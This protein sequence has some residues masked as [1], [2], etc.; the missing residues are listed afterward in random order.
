VDPV[1]DPLLH[2]KSQHNRCRKFCA[3][4]DK[5]TIEGTGVDLTDWYIYISDALSF[6]T[7][8][9]MMETEKIFGT[10]VFISTLTRLIGR[11]NLSTFIRRER[12]MS[13]EIYMLTAER[14]TT[15]YLKCRP[16]NITTWRLVGNWYEDYEDRSLS[17]DNYIVTSPGWAGQPR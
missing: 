16:R 12:L 13:H 11:E 10:L 7:L 14:Y 6:I 15:F 3:W 17:T 9:L 1:P 4:S 2:R 8:T 5:S